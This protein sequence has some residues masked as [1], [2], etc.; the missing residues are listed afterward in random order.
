[1]P[2]FQSQAIQPFTGVSFSFGW[3]RRHKN[4]LLEELHVQWNLET[5][6]S[7]WTTIRTKFIL[8]NPSDRI[9]PGGKPF[10]GFRK[11]R[12]WKKW[13]FLKHYLKKIY[14]HCPEKYKCEKNTLLAI[15]VLHRVLCNC[16]CL[17]RTL[18]LCVLENLLVADVMMVNF[19]FQRS[20]DEKITK[21]LSILCKTT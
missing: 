17:F 3:G 2:G 5:F 4:S 18:K 15:I 21:N 1:M 10:C 12:K 7:T 9:S 8:T 16:P 19:P 13:L 11:T 20:M 14:P 6:N